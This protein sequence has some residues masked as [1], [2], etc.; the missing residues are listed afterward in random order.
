MIKI[1]LIFFGCVFAFC[2]DNGA[3]FTLDE[4]RQIVTDNEL[5]L[6]W[7]A[8]KEP[9]KSDFK[10]AGRYCDELN[11][12]GFTDWRLP[13]MTELERLVLG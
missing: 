10:G 8:S 3:V 7:Q 4:A 11:L 6:M 12:A 9:I 5:N 2:A 13:G 1:L